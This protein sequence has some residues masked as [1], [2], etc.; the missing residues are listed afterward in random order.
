MTA[1]I[2]LFNIKTITNV[3]NVY[4]EIDWKAVEA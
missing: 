2:S 1:H 4:N 3:F